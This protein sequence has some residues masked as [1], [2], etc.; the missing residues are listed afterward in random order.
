MDTNDNTNISK[1]AVRIIAVSALVTILLT[2]TAIAAASHV[3]GE[4]NKKD[5]AYRLLAI[6]TDR[7]TKAASLDAASAQDAAV[8][9]GVAKE[10][11][12]ATRVLKRVVH[13]MKI[14]ARR[15]MDK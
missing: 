12:R 9:A 7:D 1:R 3:Q 11:K 10:K 5:D 14:V 15:K 8:K 4:Y 13:K 6:K 2:V